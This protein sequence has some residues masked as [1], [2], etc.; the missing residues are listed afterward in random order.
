M[1]LDPVELY[2]A[3]L[4]AELPWR[5]VPFRFITGMVAGLGL[6]RLD[7]ALYTSLYGV[8]DDQGVTFADNIA[9]PIRLKMRIRPRKALERLAGKGLLDLY[10]R[11]GFKWGRIRGYSD[12]V[13]LQRAKRAIYP[14]EGGIEEGASATAEPLLS[15]PTPPSII[16][17]SG[18]TRDE[19]AQ[20][21]GVRAR[22]GGL[23]L[24]ATN[25]ERRAAYAATEATAA[26]PDAQLELEVE[27]PKPLSVGLERLAKA[28]L[29]VYAELKPGLK[30]AAQRIPESLVRTEVA[31]L[32]AEFGIRALRS[33]MR[34]IEREA[35]GG[36]T[37]WWG[38]PLANLERKVRWEHDENPTRS[39]DASVERAEAAAASRE[40][41]PPQG[42]EV[43]VE[44]G[45]RPT[46]S[47]EL[48]VAWARASRA[49][50]QQVEPWDFK[51][52]IMPVKAAGMLDD[53]A[54]LGVPDESHGR[55]LT[56]HFK[57][58]IA[59]ALAEQGCRMPVTFAP[60]DQC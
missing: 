58:F 43:P 1:T 41:A 54:I 12:L 56:E 34:R 46:P 49:V 25:G 51:H 50:Q 35:A 32:D 6:S 29:A 28:W 10:E 20:T 36:D 30:P 15:P 42:A 27:V 19:R 11:D 21:S 38:D 16:P 9:L 31:R 3:E 5:A 2:Q 37:K 53:V 23:V 60:W 24:A 8:C 14:V 22:E 57:S 48:E 59:A 26:E 13:G 47:P 45:P 52:W 33:A 17:A 40:Q 39:H 4:A 18:K 7:V 44:Q 55:W